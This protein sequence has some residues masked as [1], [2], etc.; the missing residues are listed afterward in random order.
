MTAQ[1]EIEASLKRVTG[2]TLSAVQWEVKE[3]PG[4]LGETEPVLDAVSGTYENGNGLLV[5]T[6]RR[7]IFVDKGLVGSRVEDFPYDK[8][9]SLQYQTGLLLGTEDDYPGRLPTATA[10]ISA[11]ANI[12]PEQVRELHDCVRAGDR[13]RAGVLSAR[14]Q[15]VRAITKEHASPAVLKALAQERHGA[16]MG[17]VRPPLVPLPV[18]YDATATLRRIGVSVP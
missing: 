13:S 6:D 8:I 11:L 7:V 9:T 18:D 3:L 2:L 16:P 14:L 1:Q 17:T 10:V 15:E 5:A 4:I 12:V